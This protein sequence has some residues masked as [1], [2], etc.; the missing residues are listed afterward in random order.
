MRDAAKC[1]RDLGWAEAI[2]QHRSP[3]DLTEDV[4]QLPHKAK[5]FLNYLRKQG[6][7]VRMKTSPWHMSRLRA[8]LRRGPHKSALEYLDFLDSEMAQMVGKGQWIVLPW[9]VVKHLKNLRLSPIGI[10]PQR[11]RRPR[12]IVDYSYYLVNL[13]TLELT[14]HEAM[15]FGTALK[16]IIRKVLNADP[17]HGPVFFAK[18]DVKDGFYRV[19]VNV[20]DIPHLGVVLPPD[21]DGTDRVA[22]P[23]TLPMGWVNSPPLFCAVTETIAD[24]TNDRLQAQWTPPPHHLEQIA[25][26][27]PPPPTDPVPLVPPPPTVLAPATS[28]PPPPL[29]PPRRKPLMSTDCYV[30][31]FVSLCQGPPKRR[32]TFLRT[33][34]HTFHHVFRQLQSHDPA[35]REEPISL[36][37]L[38]KGESYWETRKVI[39]GWILDSAKQTI[40]LPPHRLARLYAI[41]DDLVPSKKRIATKRWHKVL[42]ELRSMVLAIPGLK[43][44]FSL[45]QEAFRHEN[46]GRIR[47]S[48]A[49][50]EFLADIRLLVDDLAARPTRMREIV[51]TD[52]SNVG[53]TD[54]AGPG[55]GGVFFTPPTPTTPAAQPFLWRS[56]FPL[57]IQ[58]DLVSFQNPTGS[59]TNSDL[60][61][62]GTIAQLDIVCHHQDVREA[63]ILTMSDNTP[64]VAWQ[65]KGSTTTTK[66][67]AYLLRLQAL[68]QR[69][70]RYH[71]RFSHIPGL[72]NAMADD[73]SRLWHLSDTELLN[74]F[75][76]HYPQS[77]PWTLC[78]LR[79]AMHSALI[80]ALLT[81][82]PDTASYLSESVPQIARG[83]FGPISALASTRTL[84]SSVSPTP[85]SSSKSLPSGSVTAALPKTKTTSLS[86]LIQWTNTY[87]TWARRS[88]SWGPLTLD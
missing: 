46:A 18:L 2:R 10:V 31:D 87:E 11:D 39:L 41:L 19:H 6:A 5:R 22:F 44:M 28:V 32:R 33:L 55:M 68:H 59:I 50:H 40:E 14:A 26:T 3:P 52:P 9:E 81:K 80:S 16:R 49:L 66:A 23:L 69:F 21:A 74:H 8:A 64:A 4:G 45:L 24:I 17:R 53:A 29:R 72:S 27:P 61:L 79:P 84:S 60:E 76:L 13:E 36:S 75:N 77:L 88:P 57:H 1:V 42:G 70:H 83:T 56:P 20:N 58:Q 67:P 12:I 25:D 73:C 38:L 65:G 78:R 30:D 63:T 51:P 54:A 34:F 86:G 82:R 7:P 48:S 85:S 62:A 37:K 15:Q 35:T 43:G 47:L 71:P